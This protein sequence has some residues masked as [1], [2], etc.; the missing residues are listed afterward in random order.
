MTRRGVF[1]R[2]RREDLGAT[3]VVVI[4]LMTVL[5]ICAALVVDIGAIQARKA[6]LQDAADAAALAIA[7]ECFEHP[8]TSPLGC[9]PTVVAA[10]AATAGAL[11]TA[12]VNDG[13]AAVETVEF[14]TADTVRVTLRSTQQGYFGGIVG[15]D[16]SDVRAAATARFEQPAVPLALA[17]AAC[18]F[19][20]PGEA[21]VLQ[22]SLAIPTVLGGVLGDSCGIVDSESTFSTLALEP[23]TEFLAGILSLLLPSLPNLH[24]TTGLVSG[25]WLTSSIAIPGITPDSCTYD[26]NLI[27]TITATVSKLIPS[28]CANVVRSWGVSPSNPQRVILPVFENGLDQLVLDDVLSVGA[29]DRYAVFDVTA[30]SFAGLLGLGTVAGSDVMLCRSTDGALGDAVLDLLD[31]LT[32]DLLGWLGLQGGITG[33]LNR[34]TGCQA[35][36]GTFVGFVDSA[37]AAQLLVGVQLVE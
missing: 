14:P 21:T 33:L 24:G 22:A 18:A 16:G 35:L 17:F 36:Q 32:G 30:Y 3:S 25:G 12:N 19:P 15:V 2:L 5:L 11:A 29:V 4:V 13:A 8:G 37:E 34:I 1:A 28:R 7:Q 9:A 10:G 6:Q 23:L 26:P 31:G 20:E 27:T